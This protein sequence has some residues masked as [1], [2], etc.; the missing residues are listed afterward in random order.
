MAKLNVENAVVREDHV[1]VLKTHDGKETNYLNY[2]KRVPTKSEI[3]TALKL[4]YE[5]GVT[6]AFV[7]VSYKLVPNHRR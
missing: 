4:N 2:G 6:E 5:H 3:E 7:R 1:L